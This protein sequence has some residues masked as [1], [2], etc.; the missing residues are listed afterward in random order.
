MAKK[1]K[2]EK[3][4]CPVCEEDLYYNENIPKESELLI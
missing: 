1:K 3:D 4:L 2:N